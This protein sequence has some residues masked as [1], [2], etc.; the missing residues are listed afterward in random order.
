MQIDSGTKN[1]KK[2]NKWINAVLR[3]YF[4]F[5]DDINYFLNIYV[6]LSI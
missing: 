2:I 4:E 1:Y 6:Y 3:I 5:S